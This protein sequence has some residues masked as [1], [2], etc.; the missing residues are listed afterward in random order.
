MQFFPTSYQFISLQAKYSSQH[1]AL[2][3]PPLISETKFH[4][5]TEAQAKL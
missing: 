3:H 5:Y 1:P 2:K 4:I